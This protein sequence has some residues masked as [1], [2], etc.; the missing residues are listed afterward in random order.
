MLIP[1]RAPPRAGACD[2]GESCC[3]IWARVD[4]DPGGRLD[5]QPLMTLK[6]RLELHERL[7]ALAQL[8]SSSPTSAHQRS[9]FTPQPH[10]QGGEARP[11]AMFPTPPRRRRRRHGRDMLPGTGTDPSLRSPAVPSETPTPW[12]NIGRRRPPASGLRRTF[13]ATSTEN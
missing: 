6:L 9:G 3:P 2:P 7:E 5:E 12:R 11:E 4:A 10:E 13:M 1:P 8:S